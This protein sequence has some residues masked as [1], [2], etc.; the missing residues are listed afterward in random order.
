[1]ANLKHRLRRLA[2]TAGELLPDQR[3]CPA[4][5]GRPLVA[6]SDEPENTGSSRPYDGPGGTCRFCR[7]PPPGV[8]VLQLPEPVA[9]YFATLPWADSP[10]H[11]HLEKAELLV[12]LLGKRDM[13]E[14]DR[15][16]ARLYERDANGLRHWQWPQTG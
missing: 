16:V 3:R 11:R 2:Q 1:M 5:H 15:I 7:M 12:A 4:C 8:R 9:K 13:Q 14:V 10:V 6:F